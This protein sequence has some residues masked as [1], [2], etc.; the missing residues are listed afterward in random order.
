MKKHEQIMEAIGK[1]TGD[2]PKFEYLSHLVLGALSVAD[3]QKNK[4]YATRDNLVETL[5]ESIDSHNKKWQTI[6]K[7]ICPRGECGDI[8]SDNEKEEIK[9]AFGG[10]FVDFY[11][12][13]HVLCDYANMDKAEI[14]EYVEDI[15]SEYNRI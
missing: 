8:V 11:R 7:A 13:I 9:M 2:D 4:T 12:I 15:A 14:L 5:F 3:S 1:I 6:K 10:A